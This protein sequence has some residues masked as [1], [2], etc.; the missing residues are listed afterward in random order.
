MF[1]RRIRYYRGRIV[2]QIATKAHINEKLASANAGI[3]A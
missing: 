1:R 3:P 2:P